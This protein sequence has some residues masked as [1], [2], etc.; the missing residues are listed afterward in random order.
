MVIVWWYKM[1]NINLNKI[2]THCNKILLVIIHRS[3]SVVPHKML[4]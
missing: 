4:Q 2:K 3:N 1:Y